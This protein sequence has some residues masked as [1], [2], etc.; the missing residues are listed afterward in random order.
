MTLTATPSLF[1][2][3]D[4]V[5][6]SLDFENRGTVPISG[7][8]RILIQGPDGELA[9]EFTQPLSGLPASAS[10]HIEEFWDTTGLTGGRYLIIGQGLYAS[11]STEP[12]VVEARAQTRLY[13]PCMQRNAP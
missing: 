1:D 9:Q 5:T 2:P 6:L 10:A 12:Y 4:L 13:L 3:G 11:K 7:T 8:V